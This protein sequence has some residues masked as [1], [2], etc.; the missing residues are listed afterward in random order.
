[1][2]TQA[3]TPTTRQRPT[4]KKVA[5][6]NNSDDREYDDMLAR[7]QSRFL[8]NT[9]NGTE[10]V[11][12]TNLDGAVMFENYLLG[13]AASERQY[14][15]CTCCR[16]FFEKYAGLAV[17]DSNGGHKLAIFNSDDAHENSYHTALQHTVR[18]S[19]PGGSFDIT[20]VFYDD[21]P[22]WGQ[23]V[24]GEWKHYA[25]WPTASQIHNDKTKTPFQKM[26]EKKEDFNTISRA[27]SEFTVDN[28]KT[29]VRILEADALSRSEK[30][31]GVAQWLLDLKTMMESTKEKW[32]RNN[33]L[34]SAVA[35]APVG[36][37]HPR[38]SM[39][40]T[41]LEDIASGLTY[42]VINKRFSDKMHP[43]QYQ[44]PTAAPKEGAIKQA[45]TLFDQLQLAPALARRFA[46]LDEVPGIWYPRPEKA[47]EAATGGIFGHLSA[48][49][50][51]APTKIELPPQ[52]MTWVRF[53]ETVLP[54]ASK[55]EYK[56]PSAFVTATFCALVTAVDP[57]APPL[58]QWDHP[59]R[60]NPVCW[61]IW[62]GGS[63]A[64]SF[65][66]ASSSWIPVTAVAL[67]PHQWHDETAN[68]HKGQQAI[69]LLEGARETRFAGLALFP[70]DMRSELHGVRSVIE[71]HSKS[72][73]LVGEKEGSAC[74]V[75][76]FKAKPHQ[77]GTVQLL[78]R[79]TDE[80]GNQQEYK[81]DRWE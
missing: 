42:E 47:A 69:F 68:E 22:L 65:G 67:P 78:I 29:A 15:T 33:R 54:S 16:R 4:V 53:R 11:F 17:V 73:R 5:A 24:T 38:S 79:S 3:K 44:R 13:F 36:F 1:M 25:I 55:L 48:K 6:V 61:Y 43:L 72:G 52:L 23:P 14:H 56:T 74:G 34:W 2:A 28:L 45:E 76:L 12:T 7:I 37:C 9:K 75:M 19:R 64:S 57:N 71:A 51:P 81:I 66:L 46:R 32:R 10:P 80:D 21:A 20:G 41:L 39:I 40:G 26:A 60:R 49:K 8:A 58:L 30:F 50:K 35:T 27:L 70:E 59:E 77:S 62:H 18:G 31:L 63:H